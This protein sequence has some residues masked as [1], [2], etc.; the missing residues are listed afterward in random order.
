MDPISL[1]GAAVSAIGFVT[2]LRSIVPRDVKRSRSLGIQILEDEPESPDIDI[3]FV[4]GIKE[5]SMSTWSLTNPDGTDKF[6]WPAHLQKRTNARILL[7]GY[8]TVAPTAEYLARRTL[9]HQAEYL[10]ESLANARKDHPRRP[11]IFIAHSL[12]GIVVKSGLIFSNQSLK[13]NS[14]I[15]DVVRS[16]AGIVFL[17]TPHKV[18]GHLNSSTGSVLRTIAKV[19]GLN[20]EV[21]KHLDGE[22]RV[23][24]DSL[25]PFEA[26]KTEIPMI[27][28]FE[29]QG[30]RSFGIIVP[31]LSATHGAETQFLDADHANL[32]RFYGPDDDN[33]MLVLSAIQRLYERAAFV[34]EKKW[35]TYQKGK[36]V[37]IHQHNDKM[38]EIFQVLSPIPPQSPNFTGREETLRTMKHALLG[39]CPPDCPNDHHTINLHGPGGIGKTQIALEFAHRFRNQFSSVFWIPSRTRS[40]IEREFL[41]IARSLRL[42]T[43]VTGDD[44]SAHEIVHSVLEWLKKSRNTDWLLIFDDVEL[45][46]AADIMDLIPSTT[47]VHGH[48][49][50]TS[51]IPMNL[52]FARTYTVDPLR[53]MESRALLKKYLNISHPIDIYLDVLSRE[54]NGNP[55]ALSMAGEYMRKAKMPPSEYVTVYNRMQTEFSLGTQSNIDATFMKSMA[56]IAGSPAELLF[57]M[58]CMLSLDPIPLWIFEEGSQPF[59]SKRVLRDSITM[60]EGL[61]LVHHLPS[62]TH[63]LVRHF[64]RDYG[65]RLLLTNR[66]VDACRELCETA[67]YVAVGRKQT[68]ARYLGPANNGPY[69]FEKELFDLTVDALS[70]ILLHRPSS[71]GWTVNLEELGKVCQAHGRF[72]EAAKFYE[73]YVVDNK[74]PET[75]TSRTK[76]RL[77]ITRRH[78]KQHSRIS[79]NSKDKSLNIQFQEAVKAAS[80][81]ESMQDLKCINREQDDPEQKLEVLRMIIEAQ[82][83]RSGPLSS[84][85]LE[86]IEEISHRL[87]DQGFLDEAEARLRRVL[88]SYQKLRGTHHKSTAQVAEQLASICASLYKLDEAEAFCKSAIQN[89]ETRLPRDHPSTQKC[90]AQLAFIN[91]L[92]GNYVDAE[93]LF[94]N[95]IDILTK[96]IGHN[97]P[98]VLRIQHNYAL[99]MMKLGKIRQSQELLKD[100]LLRMEAHQEIYTMN[101]RRRTAIKLFEI[102]ERDSTLG[103]GDELWEMARSLEENYGLESNSGL[104]ISYS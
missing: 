41:Q 21:L 16:T 36:E 13:E 62:E 96:V 51:R 34:V 49:I 55:L 69:T 58:C 29:K 52:P 10:V 66:Q 23:L 27:S 83:D 53:L 35:E 102:I 1:V 22:S 26:L 80:D 56:S 86:S 94:I 43:S 38:M 39:E 57:S 71:L 59:N 20:R 44:D 90:L 15:Q 3:C 8:S 30:T 63:I 64:V 74:G 61:N 70:M 75:L 47:C 65:Q 32:A 17:G 9:Y 99:D 104:D 42:V 2:Y 54:L 11:L 95:A 100:V 103:E 12:G 60:L 48:A 18:H 77:A 92:R 14:P 28:F 89:Y 82:E 7:Y 72:S 101:T 88:I 68:L 98:D 85:T 81:D 73:L 6:W 19:S 50:I 45:L 87:I 5:D 91:Y 31:P 84:S 46:T 78:S 4:H 24:Q 93:P 25:E 79:T 40:S 97:H 33:Y 37:S 76:L 67:S